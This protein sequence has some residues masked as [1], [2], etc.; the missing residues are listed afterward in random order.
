MGSNAASTGG[1]GPAGITKKGTLGTEQDAENAASRHKLRKFITEGGNFIA[2]GGITGAILKSLLDFK[3]KE[4]GESNETKVIPT[5]S[6]DNSGRNVIKSITSEA[7]AQAPT[8]AEVSQSAATDA[9]SLDSA[10]T[11]TDTSILK[12]KRTNAKGRSATILTGSKG[13]EDTNL[14]LGTASLLGR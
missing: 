13:L 4:N 1:V 14:K 8:T 2:G 5:Y 9:T 12:K 7:I 10:T 11:M 6:K 3:K